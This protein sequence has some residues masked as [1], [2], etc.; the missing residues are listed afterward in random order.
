MTYRTTLTRKGQ[1]TVPKPLRD[2]FNLRASATLV[3]DA[4]ESGIH[5]RPPVDL[6]EVVKR[7][8]V[9]RKKDPVKAR[10]YMQKK[11]GLR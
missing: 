6:L 10:G 5:I 1:A 4:D 8:R 9:K 11:Y 7:I 3:W 2:R